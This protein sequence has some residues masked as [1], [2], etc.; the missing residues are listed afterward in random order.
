MYNRVDV[1]EGTFTLNKPSIKYQHAINNA[2]KE[3]WADHL[4]KLKI[5]RSRLAAIEAES[6]GAAEVSSVTPADKPLS[7]PSLQKPEAPTAPKLGAN[8]T[9]RKNTPVAQPSSVAL[10]PA[11]V[12]EVIAEMNENLKSTDTLT[13]VG[14]FAGVMQEYKALGDS[15]FPRTKVKAP[16]T[17]LNSGEFFRFLFISAITSATDAGISATLLGCATGVFLRSVTLAPSLGAVGASGFCRLGLDNGLSAGV[18][19]LTSAAPLDSASIAANLDL[20]IFNFSK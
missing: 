5:L 2:R 3:F 19:E 6:N 18:T 9:E 12:A 10:I 15:I 4:E 20:K 13:V 1:I 14:A 16:T 8:V 11:S 17:V 7:K